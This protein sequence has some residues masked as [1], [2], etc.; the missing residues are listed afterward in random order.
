M[1][2][3]IIA[4]ES[5]SENG[6]YYFF[7]F[8]QAV[9]GSYYLR[10]ARSDQLSDNTYL[11]TAVVFFE[12]N[13]ELAIQALSSLFS[14]AARYAAQKTATRPAPETERATGIKSWE[15]SLRPREK[16]IE[17]GRDAMAD[18]ELLAMLIGSGSPRETAV[19]L[20]DR[21][22]ASV[23]YGLKRLSELTVEDLCRFH[24]MGPAKALSIISSMELAARL[25]KR[26]NKPVWL[27]AL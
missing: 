15:P 21:I 25:V 6:T 18:A 7:D 26:Q 13:F 11:R 4:T 14:N 3:P 20:A 9:N 8:M 24:G 19:D 5:F 17:Q 10:I 23:D 22:L 27:R 16:M 1:K 2:N 12:Q